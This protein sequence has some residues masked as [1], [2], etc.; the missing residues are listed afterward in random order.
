M[1]FIGPDAAVAEDNLRYVEQRI[2]GDFTDLLFAAQRAPKDIVAALAGG[3]FKHE[4]AAALVPTKGGRQA[5]ITENGEPARKGDSFVP[6]H[7]AHCQ[8]EATALVRGLAGH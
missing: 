4:E 2:Q 7:R 3:L 6:E 1:K 5:G 8:F